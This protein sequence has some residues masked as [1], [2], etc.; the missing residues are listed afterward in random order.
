MLPAGTVQTACKAI[1]AQ[2]ASVGPQESAWK[3]GVSPFDRGALQ[4][5]GRRMIAVQ[6]LNMEGLLCSLR[7]KCNLS[8]SAPL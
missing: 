6:I 4:R 8:G 5:L 7:A 1:R 3:P 2:T